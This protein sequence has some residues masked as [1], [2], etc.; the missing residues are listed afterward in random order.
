[1]YDALG[2]ALIPGRLYVCAED[3][4]DHVMFGAL[5]WFGSDGSFYDAECASYDEPREVRADADFYVLQQGN[6]N[7]YYT[8]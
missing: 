6:V 4:D 2:N 7:P 1:M 3:R 8:A 5:V